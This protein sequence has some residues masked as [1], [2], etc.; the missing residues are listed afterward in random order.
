MSIFDQTVFRRLFLLPALTLG[1][2]C[3][4]PAVA[5][6]VTNRATFE[7]LCTVQATQT[8][9]G[10]VGSPDFPQNY[11]A[12]LGYGTMSSTGIVVAGVSYVGTTS[13]GVPNS[14]ETYILHTNV[15][16]PYT[17]PGAYS[18]GHGDWAL[19]AGKSARTIITLPGGTTAFGTDIGCSIFSYGHFIVRAVLQGGSTNVMPFYGTER[20]QFIGYLSPGPDIDRIL[21]DSILDYGAYTVLDNVT[22]GTVLPP[23]PQAPLQIRFSSVELSFPSVLGKQYQPQYT[24]ELTTNIWTNLGPAIPGTGDPLLIHDDIPLGKPQRYYRIVEAASQSAKP[25]PPPGSL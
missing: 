21:I 17:Q 19:V 12:G 16:P 25:A 5:Q 8:F 6:F 13:Y 22:T 18:I 1:I 24:S 10:L 7:S 20:S 3:A 9:D 15:G 23:P 11:G 4:G 2:L 14:F